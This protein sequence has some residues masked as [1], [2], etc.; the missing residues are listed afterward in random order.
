MARKRILSPEFFRHAEIYDAEVESGLPL[1][2]AWAGLWT[3][4]DRRGLFWWKPREMKFDVLPYDPVDLSTVLDTLHRY[5]FVERYVIDG[6]HFGRIPSFERWQTFHKHER[7]SDVPNPTDPG[8]EPA[9]GGAEPAIGRHEPSISVSVAVTG[10]ASASST[11]CG[12]TSPG[13][14]DAPPAA[15][16]TPVSEI[17][18]KL[19]R[20]AKETSVRWPEWEQVERN[21]LYELWR[22]ELGEV[23][24]KQWVSALGPVFGRPPNGVAYPDLC[25]GYRAWLKSAAFGGNGTRFASPAACAKALTACAKAVRD[26]PAG[27]ARDNA[28]DLIVHGRVAA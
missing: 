7:P 19:T 18:S 9:I 8:V 6:K 14:A 26:I 5:G 16:E 10:T 3:V 28:L 13:V 23:A 11:A 27:E 25:T 15:G 17:R 21:R 12:L 24:F 1:R 2:L 22:A 4:C 20:P